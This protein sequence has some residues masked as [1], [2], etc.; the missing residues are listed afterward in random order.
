MP[1]SVDEAKELEK[2]WLAIGEFIYEFSQLEFSIRLALAEALRLGEELEMF[3]AVTSPYD[4]RTLCRVTRTVLQINLGPPDQDEQKREA[5]EAKKKEIER[6]FNACMAMNTDRVRI[7]HGTWGIWSGARQVSRET[8][9]AKSHFE[10]P[11]KIVEK[12]CE[13]GKLI[14]R[15]LRFVPSRG[16][17]L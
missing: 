10:E 4:F 7:A 1:L 15:V 3:D 8:L 16:R 5:Q 2:L 9:E 13:T 12:F 14:D 6:T 17:Q 11:E